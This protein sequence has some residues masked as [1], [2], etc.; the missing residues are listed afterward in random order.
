M[1]TMKTNKGRLT[2]MTVMLMIIHTYEGV[3][4]DEDDD[5]EDR[6]SGVK[7]QS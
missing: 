3:D 2:M 7:Q 6:N 4:V 5:E 1:I